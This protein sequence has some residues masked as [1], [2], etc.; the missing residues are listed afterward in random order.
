MR[1]QVSVY[2][3]E[4]FP[5]EQCPNCGAR[6]TDAH[7]MLCPDK[8]LSCFLIDNVEELIKWLETDGRT[9]PKL[10]YWILKYIMM[11]NNK[12]FLALGRM[13]PQ[14]RALAESQDTIG[15]RN[16]TEGYIS[17]HFFFIQQHHLAMLSSYLNNSDWTNNSLP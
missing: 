7:L 5:D 1:A 16:F 2:L 17:V 12:P 11:G 6:E 13:S 9:D 14:M 10:T 3:G 8:D 15:W 4:K